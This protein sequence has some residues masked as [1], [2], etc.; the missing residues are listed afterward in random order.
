MLVIFLSIKP[1]LLY[2]ETY[3]L[4]INVNKYRLFSE[5]DQDIYLIVYLNRLRNQFKYFS[6]YQYVTVDN[7]THT[8]RGNLMPDH[9][10]TKAKIESILE[11]TKGKT[12]GQIDKNNVF[13]KT[14]SKPKITGIAG[15]VIEQSVLGYPADIKQEADLLVDGIPVELK[16]TGIRYSKKDKKAVEAKEPMSITAV[17]PDTIVNEE[18]GTSKFWN[19]MAHTL[20]VYYLYD[21]DKTVTAAEYANFPIQGYQF[22]QFS[23]HD[24]EI[25]K[26]DWSIVRNFIRNVDEKDK[27]I[28]Y[29][30]ISKLRNQMMYMDTAPKWPHRPRFRLKRAVVTNIVKEHFGV[31]FEVLRDEN[32]FSSYS[33][34][35]EKL[36]NF[37]IKYK[38]KTMREIA[39]ELGMN[40]PQN[41]PVN[42]SVAENIVVRM[43]GSKKGKLR[44][45][46]TFAKLGI[47]PKTIVQT[48]K[49]KRTEDTKFEIIDFDEWTNKSIEFE[50]SYIYNFFANQSML[51]IIFRE[52]GKDTPLN[53]TIFKG[54][55]RLQFD[56]DTLQTKLKPVWEK[57]RELVWNNEV[58]VSIV[59]NKNG[60][61]RITPSTKLPMEKT[62]FPKSSDHD[63]FMR[64]S[65]ANAKDKTLTINGQK[66]YNQYI[67]VKGKF[68]INLLESKNYI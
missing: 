40:F 45:I 63:F 33:E 61:I 25:L 11:K 57:V 31:H 22:H 44:Q 34:L 41:K 43:F 18:F 23:D 21:S 24:K 20:F 67:W 13:D 8:I 10:F 48:D 66:M 12:L 46:D 58:K 27:D 59:H 3:V 39:V 15:D 38:N 53:Q 42:K 65:G 50:E 16:T 68:M 5:I 49:K 55:K 19:K 62:N 37:T 36:H 7:I 2:Y 17:S 26:N 28:E 51:F 6:L 30:K 54:F 52:T 32:S 14:I 29:P 4:V 64:G 1:N 35:D 9:I 60:A 47:I 56:D